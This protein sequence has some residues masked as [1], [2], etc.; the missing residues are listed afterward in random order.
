ML[1]R[2]MRNWVYGGFLSALALLGLFPLI[3]PHWPETLRLTYLFLPIYMIHQYE[4]H[5]ADRFRLFFNLTLGKGREVLTPAAVFVINIFGV[6]GVILLA[7][8][9]SA[10]VAPGLGLIAVYLA[11]VNAVVHIVHAIIFRRYNPG[12]GTA[13]AI[14]LPLGGYAIMRFDAL[15]AGGRAFQ[16]I[17]L[18][19]A[20][21]IHAAIVAYALRRR[22]A[23]API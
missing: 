23:L 3:A 4:E 6:W 8:Y 12:L 22:S 15:G 14:F 11:V 17:A 21:V 1:D 19:V 20:I 10:Y 16:A 13:V 9:L 7:C 5:D 2:L 18:F